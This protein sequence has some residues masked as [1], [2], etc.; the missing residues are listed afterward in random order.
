MMQELQKREEEAICFDQSLPRRLK[1]SL[2]VVSSCYSFFS[3][4]ETR[5]R[6]RKQRR[7]ELETWRACC[8]LDGIRGLCLG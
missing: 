5:R 4:G 7:M 8:H 3:L 6:R 2:I 1:R